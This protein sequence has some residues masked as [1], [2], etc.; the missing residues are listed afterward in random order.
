[1]VVLRDK[2]EVAPGHARLLAIGPLYVL[3]LLAGKKVCGVEDYGVMAFE[4]VGDP[5]SPPTEG[6]YLYTGILRPD[7]IAR[8]PE[9][10]G[11]WQLDDFLRRQGLFFV[12]IARLPEGSRSPGLNLPS[13][14]ASVNPFLTPSKRLTFG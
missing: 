9:S 7:K 11:A 8:S 3:N 10:V 4:D 13:R 5:K 2:E 14:I 12:E 1:M 6:E